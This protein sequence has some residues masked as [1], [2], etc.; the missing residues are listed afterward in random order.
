M[1]RR[2]KPNITTKFHIDFSWWEKHKINFRIHL[3][4]QLC[5]DCRESYVS[6]RETE[7]ID[8]IDPAT[9]EVRRVDGLWQAL[10]TCCSLKPEY[11]TDQI[12]LG[13]AAFRVFLAN[14]NTPLSALELSEAIGRK[15]PETI[16][17][18]LAGG[19]VYKGIRPVNTGEKKDRR[20]AKSQKS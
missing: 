9:A 4:N 2:L 1:V 18:T 14:A 15:T 12:P 13:T 6:Y 19:K 11:I 16:L 10:R 5:P 7:D 17:A 20:S 3:W 8:W